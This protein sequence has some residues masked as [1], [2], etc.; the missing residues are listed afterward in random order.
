MLKLQPKVFSEEE[1]AALDKV[2]T[3]QEVVKGVPKSVDPVNYPVFDIPINAKALVYVPNHVVQ[4]KDDVLELRMD[5]PLV[6][7]ITD[8][9]RFLNYRCIS[10]ITEAGYSGNCP[11]CDGVDDCWTLANYL[12]ESKCRQR[13]LNEKD[14]ENRE[15]KNIRSDFFSERV[16]KDALRKFVFPIVV[17]ETVNNDGKTL[18]KDD[19]GQVSYKIMWYDISEA[20]YESTWKKAFESMEDEP[21]HPGGHCFVLN[22]TYKSKTG[23][24]NKRDSAKNLNVASKRIRGLEKIM[25]ILDKQTEDWTPRK[26]RETVIQ[27]IFYPEEGLQELADEVLEQTRQLIEMYKSAGSTAGTAIETEESITFNLEEKEEEVSEADALHTDL[28]EE[29]EEEEGAVE[30]NDDDDE[31]I[32]IG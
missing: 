1:N 7:S 6:H 5:K 8:G 28:D 29:E 26:A 27:N 32:D 2:V 30:T 4:G 22:Y 24:H 20:Q 13:G 17:F 9:R 23:E 31:P 10:G 12:I 15:V 18:V 19:N 3:V 14:T 25:P 21:S 11:L 16:V